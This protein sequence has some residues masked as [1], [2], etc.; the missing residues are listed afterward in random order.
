MYYTNPSVSTLIL[1][2]IHIGINIL[3]IIDSGKTETKKFQEILFIPLDIRDVFNVAAVP[4]LPKLHPL[5]LNVLA[6]LKII[7]TD[8][9]LGIYGNCVSGV[10]PLGK[11]TL[12]L[13]NAIFMHAILFHHFHQ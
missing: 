12:N 1:R 8:S 6:H 3:I 5:F 4:P 10:K 9:S 13:F 7:D 2:K 11:K